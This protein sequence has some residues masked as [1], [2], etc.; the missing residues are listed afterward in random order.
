SEV[1][2]D[3][4]TT[5]ELLQAY[6]AEHKPAGGGT[7]VSWWQESLHNGVLAGTQKKP[8]PLEVQAGLAAKLPPDK[9]PAFD[10]NKIDLVFAPDP[11]VFDGRFANNGWLQEVPRP[12]TKL[13][14]D[15]AALLSPQTA[16]ELNVRASVGQ[17]GGGEHG[18]FKADVIQIR[19]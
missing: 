5:L 16:R 7:F 15:N 14:W 3:E 9:A 4:R 13:C 10:P 11:A 6:W 1:G 2:Y 12:I 8:I 17:W 19:F 18:E